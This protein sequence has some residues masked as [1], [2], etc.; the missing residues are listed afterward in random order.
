MKISTKGRYALEAIVDLALHAHEGCV[1]LKSIAR[2][3]EISEAY[4]LQ[5]FIALRRQGL[6]DSIRGA[7]G[8]YILGKDPSKITV[9]MVLTAVESS[10]APVA[11]LADEKELHCNRK[12]LCV[13]RSFWEGVMGIIT[14]ITESITIE[15]L[16]NYYNRDYGNAYEPEYFI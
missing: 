13:T 8:G 3:C 12:D 7:Q 15:D 10:L 14:D 1:N 9:G 6:V 5:I 16:V 2:R 4:I 11:C